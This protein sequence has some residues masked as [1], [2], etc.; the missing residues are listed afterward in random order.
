MKSPWSLLHRLDRDCER[1]S[2]VGCLVPTSYRDDAAAAAAEAAEAADA[3]TAND[4]DDGGDARIF[5][6]DAYLFLGAAALLCAAALGGV[7]VL[8][9]VNKRL[10]QRVTE[11]APH[12][13]HISVVE[14]TKP[15][16]VSSYGH[17]SET[18]LRVSMANPMRSV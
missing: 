3:D 9:L 11:T 1:P 4:E 2:D 12:A 16:D 14:L 18:S 10:A 5:G 7:G 17:P 13:D 15:S 6:F 8:L